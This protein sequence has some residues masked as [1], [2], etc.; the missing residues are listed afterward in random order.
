MKDSGKRRGNRRDFFKRVGLIGFGTVFLRKADLV[1][2]AAAN[3]KLKQQRQAILAAASAQREA[4]DVVGRTALCLLI[5]S[6]PWP[7]GSHRAA[8]SPVHTEHIWIT[9]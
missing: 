1:R 3:E 2:G 9:S 8:I 5:N 7:P 6:T 4:A